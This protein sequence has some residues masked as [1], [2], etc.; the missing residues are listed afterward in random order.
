MKNQ[1]KQAKDKTLPAKK[2]LAWLEKRF[3]LKKDSFAKP[4]Q[5][6]GAR[7]RG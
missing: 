2:P 5:Y 1:A 3:S 6:H 4:V 7:H